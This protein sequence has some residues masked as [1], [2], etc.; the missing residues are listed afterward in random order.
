MSREFSK[1]EIIR[2]KCSICGIRNKLFTELVSENKTVG[3]KLTCCNCGHCDTF[4]FDD[5]HI[6]PINYDK[7]REVCVH[8]TTCQNKTCPYY[9]LYSIYQ[10]SKMIKSILNG[11]EYS[12][13]NE[14]V[15]D[16]ED[17]DINNNFSNTIELDIN[18][19]CKLNP[20]FH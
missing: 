20:K 15:N 3:Y 11:E 8:I 18:G 17:D 19:C 1:S 16:I 13:D 14:D 12:F 6:V 10:A 4:F 9:N 2:H 5:S 7:G